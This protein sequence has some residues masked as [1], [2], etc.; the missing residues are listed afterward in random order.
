MSRVNKLEKADILEMTVRY[1][2]RKVTAPPS[3]A[4]L[5]LAGYRQ[6][7]EQVQDLLAEQWTDDQRHQSG[8]RM[9]EHLEVCVQRLNVPPSAPNRLSFSSS[10]ESNMTTNDVQHRSPGTTRNSCSLSSDD[11]SVEEDLVTTATATA[12]PSPNHHHTTEFRDTTPKSTWRPWW[13]EPSTL[14]TH[15]FR[16]YFPSN[17]PHILDLPF[18]IIL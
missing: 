10:D 4:D 5:Y 12:R 9:I 2:K 16:C 8:R 6:C 7:I 3:P 15:F 17:L 1:L 13:T 14:H 18:V 11:D